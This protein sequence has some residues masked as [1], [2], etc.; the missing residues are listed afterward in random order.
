MGIEFKDF[1]DDSE[2][3]C[4]NKGLWKSWKR[5]TRGSRV[6][7]PI[8]FIFS[9]VFSLFLWPFATAYATSRQ[10]FC[11]NICHDSTGGASGTQCTSNSGLING[12]IQSVT[13]HTCQEAHG[14]SCSGAIDPACA[15]A[16]KNKVEDLFGR[17]DFPGCGDNVFDPNNCSVDGTFCEQCDDGNNDCNDG[18]DSNCQLIKCDDK[19]D[20]TSDTCITS[21][22]NSGACQ[23]TP[24]SNDT[25]CTDNSLCTQ[26]DSCQSGVCT[27]DPV[28]CTAK[29]VCHIAGTCN[30]ATGQCS[31]PNK[32]DDSPCG[33]NDVCDGI[34]VCKQGVCTPGTPIDCDDG[35]EC[36]ADSCDVNGICHHDPVTVG[37]GCKDGNIC[38]VEDACDANGDCHGT[39]KKC[40]DN[41]IC[42]N[43]S[44]DSNSECDP[45]QDPDCGCV[46]TD[47]N[48]S[49][50]CYTGQEGTEDVGECHGGTKTC[51][52]GEF[53]ECDG[54]VTPAVEVCDG[55]DNDCNGVID[56]GGD[57]LCDDKKACNGKEICGGEAGCKP[58]T[59]VVV[60]PDTD[61]QTFTCDDETGEIVPHNK[62]DG[63]TC[64]DT[65][66]NECTVAQCSNGT[67]I[68]NVAKP[69]N[70]ECIPDSNVCTKDVCLSGTCSHPAGNQG[71]ECRASQGVCDVAEKCDGQSVDCPTDGFKG[72]DQVCRAANGDCDVPENC[73]GQS[74]DCPNDA[75]QDNN[76]VCRP[77]AGDC[78]VPEKCDGNSKSCPTNGFKGSDVEC[79]PAAAGGCDVPENCPG[80]GASCPTNQ[81]KAPGAPCGSN[82]DTACDNPDTCD[83]KHNCQDNQEQDG[84]PC[85]D[86]TVCNGD[87]ECQAGECK[88]GTPLNCTSNNV[89]QDP[90]CDPAKGC[91]LVDN[92]HSES[93]YTG[94]EETNG[95]GLCHGG[96]KTCSNGEFGECDG[97]VVPAVEIC[98][99]LD[100]DCD[101]VIDNGFDVGE[102]CTVG[103]GEC[104]VTGKKICNP[105]HDGTVCDVQPGEP[106]EE[107]CDGLDNDC[108]GFVDNGGNDLCNDDNSCTD[109]ICN[110]VDR[111]SN[112]D[113]GT[114]EV[115]PCADT[116]RDGVCDVDDNCPNTANPDQ[117]DDDH[118]GIGNACESGGG[119]VVPNQPPPIFLSGAPPGNGCGHSLQGQYT[120]STM[121]LQYGVQ[122]FAM[123]MIMTLPLMRNR[124]IAVRKRWRRE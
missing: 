29:D 19:N 107:I 55:K 97:E 78:D 121:D 10:C 2:P 24:V 7:L 123:A 4:R 44:C 46:H 45:Q 82:S 98:D 27:G 37:T 21:G 86:N 71:T 22:N 8:F 77:S 81:F 15:D 103:E 3:E 18:C 36:T 23:N 120:S 79:R 65:D 52:N 32:P 89:C 99:G 80:D 28:I 102:S 53:G 114:C 100:N 61:C 96:T 60:P 101:G 64:T 117:A 33:N 9:L 26:G 43:D 17:C 57:S 35:K 95:V 119:A 68:Q 87:E 58:G 67:C 31:D 85:K 1:D 47:N 122:W 70:T 106:S 39:E 76:H 112:V 40:D 6:F 109:D 42:T 72:S 83:D 16:C 73:T 110:G 105:E 56:D 115:P 25:P 84:T 11:H 13:C 50:S 63:I 38:T 94:P 66:N 62:Q 30:P 92:D 41:N 5:M 113:N 54:E 104:D 34:D 14:A 69:D 91:I 74:A 108:D 118:N 12:H 20:C 48:H 75:V 51:S 88:P 124:F 49:E 111:C 59:P 90:A 93:C 116:D